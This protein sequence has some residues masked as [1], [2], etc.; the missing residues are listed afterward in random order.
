L[1]QARH[2][3]VLI[4]AWLA[5]VFIFAIQCFV[6]DA[7]RGDADPFRYY[8]CWSCYTWGVLT[9]IVVKFALHSP[10][11]AATWRRALPLHLGASFVLVADEISI[12]AVLGKLRFHHH[13]SLQEALRHYFTRRTQVSLVTLL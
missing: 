11:N 13:L 5:V 8:L 10:I 6:Y 4:A 9:P 3:A 2:T 1:Y 12:E 7:A